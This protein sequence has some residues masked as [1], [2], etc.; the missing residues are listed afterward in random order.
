MPLLNDVGDALDVISKCHQTSMNPWQT[1]Y[2]SDLRGGLTQFESDWFII[3]RTSSF[4]LTTRIRQKY[5]FTTE[6]QWWKCCACNLKKSSSNR[7]C[8]H[9]S[10][11]LALTFYSN[12]SEFWF[13]ISYLSLFS[14]LKSHPISHWL[15]RGVIT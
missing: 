15:V 5:T 3:I 7:N 2:D 1:L 11:C 12:P 13:L 14:L 4:C 10:W 9:L 8:S 6:N